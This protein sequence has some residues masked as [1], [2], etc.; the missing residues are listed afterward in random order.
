M[1]KEDWL[2]RQINQL[3]RVLGKILADLLWLKTQGQV[4]EGIIAADQA[5]KSEIDLNIDD[6]I[7]IPTEEFITTLQGVKKFNNDN[8]EKLADIL[9][10]LAEELD[11]RDIENEKRNKLYEKS[12]TIY[13]HLDSTSSIYSFDRYSKIQRIKKML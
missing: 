10:I 13:E 8:F 3:G 5:L 11:T 1:Q 6:L 7:S 4:S 9:F 2:M 12:L